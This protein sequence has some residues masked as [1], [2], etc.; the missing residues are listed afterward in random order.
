MTI[1]TEFVIVPDGD[2]GKALVQTLQLGVAAIA[3]IQVTIVIDVGRRGVAGRQR[4]NR[5]R[6]ALLKT[7]IDGFVDVVAQVD[8]VVHVF[9]GDAGKGV[10]ETEAVVLT[11]DIAQPQPFGVGLGG[12]QR[13]EPPGAAG[14][15]LQNETV[16]I[17]FETAQRRM[18]D[19]E[20]DGKVARGTCT[21]GAGE[22]DVAEFFVRRDLPVHD[23]VA[24]CG[25]A[26]RGEPG[27]Q[28]DA[29]FLRVARG[30]ALGKPR[31]LMPGCGGVVNS[32]GLPLRADIGRIDERHRAF[33]Y[34]A[35][36]PGPAR[37][38]GQAPADRARSR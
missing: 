11:G 8:D 9:L 36:R 26:L 38:G 32:A 35:Q 21:G 27:P 29:L 34:A 6:A 30:D 18:G 4:A 1:V 23:R 28:H 22:N 19:G 15:A 7:G 31:C 12:G 37:G 14:H 33:E 25:L 2:H 13:L 5:A 3:A 16:V 10:V 24:G 20:L 17:R